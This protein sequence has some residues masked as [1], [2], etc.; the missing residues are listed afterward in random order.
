MSAIKI[1]GEDGLLYYTTLLANLFQRSENGKGL[2]EANFTAA[3]KAKLASA[4]LV[5]QLF[6]GNYSD[7]NGKPTDLSQFA[8]SPGY[9]TASQVSAAILLAIG[10]LGGGIT[11]APVDELPDISS[12]APNV[13]YLLARPEP[14]EDNLRDEYILFNGAWEKIGSTSVDMSGYVRYEDI[15]PLTNSRIS[16]LVNL[17]LEELI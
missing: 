2:S 16:E 13:I 9:Q 12:A 17:A 3:E 1:M 15:L 6:S 5:S 8:N 10:N 7:L 11:L 4:A 14:E